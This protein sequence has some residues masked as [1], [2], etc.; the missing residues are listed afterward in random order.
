MT[1]SWGGWSGRNSLDASVACSFL[2]SNTHTLLTSVAFTPTSSSCHFSFHER[3]ASRPAP[4]PLPPPLSSPPLLASPRGLPSLPPPPSDP[5][6]RAGS[7][8]RPRSTI[9]RFLEFRGEQQRRRSRRSSTRCISSEREGRPDGEASKRGGERS[10]WW[11]S[12]DRMARALTSFA[13]DHSSCPS[14][15]I[16]TW[17]RVTRPSKST[18]RSPKRM[19][20]SVT[21]TRG[22]LLV[23]LLFSAARACERDV[24]RSV[25][26]DQQLMHHVAV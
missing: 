10:G 23:L 11:V 26:H 2:P 18:Y 5:P 7:P 15:I 13:L 14:G 8:Y 24:L 12:P 4:C 19:T 16:P 21:T 20:R 25:E 6:R 9:T 1:T 17:H 22:G 3:A